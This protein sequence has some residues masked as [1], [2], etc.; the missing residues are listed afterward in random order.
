MVDSL[1]LLGLLKYYGYEQL[2]NGPR[3]KEVKTAVQLFKK[4]AQKGHADAQF[5]LGMALYSGEGGIGV[6]E[7]LSSIWLSAS[8][9]QH[10]P[11][12]QWMLAT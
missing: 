9:H 11:D 5:A 10:H 4:A 1:Y 8:A 2:A 7:H 6:N 12:A 3:E